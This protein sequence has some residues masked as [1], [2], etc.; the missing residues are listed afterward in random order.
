MT[1]DLN[2]LTLVNLKGDDRLT[3][4]NKLTVLIAVCLLPTITY[5]RKSLALHVWCYSKGFL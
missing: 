4:L 3:V 5:I 1:D 2:K